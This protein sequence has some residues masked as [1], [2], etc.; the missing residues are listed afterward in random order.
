MT[1]LFI[2]PVVVWV[3]LV[4]V[5]IVVGLDLYSD[6]K[7]WIDGMLTEDGPRAVR[8]GLWGYWD[9]VKNGFLSYAAIAAG[10][11]GSALAIFIGLFLNKYI[12]LVLLSPVMAYAS[13]RT[14]E[15]LM[16]NEYPFKWGQFF[17]DIFRGVLIA[18][19][20]AS[21]ELFLALIL[22]ISALLMPFLAPLWVALLF[23]ISS[24]FYG[25][26][27]FDYV[28]ERRKAGI[29]QRIRNIRADRWLVI[30]NGAAFNLIMKVPFIGMVV[31][32]VVASVGACL[33]FVEKS[34]NSGT[35]RHL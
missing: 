1:W 35:P 13:E 33:A 29:A 26:S 18:T 17:K 5:F 16:G 21:I 6:L 34:N 12:V 9:K 25:F 30:G 28:H 22:W 19:R 10:V 23:L 32:P 15:I 3:L 27:T 2:L 31:G 4:V 11:V 24:Y 8:D 20:N 7:G 14:E